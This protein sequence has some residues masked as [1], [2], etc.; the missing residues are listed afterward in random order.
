MLCLDELMIG[1]VTDIRRETRILI[2]FAMHT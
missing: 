2:L 1:E